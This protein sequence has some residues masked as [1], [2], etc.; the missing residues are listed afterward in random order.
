[1]VVWISHLFP[2]LTIL[3]IP[4]RLCIFAHALCFL[5][6]SLF[7]NKVEIAEF[8]LVGIFGISELCCQVHVGSHG[9]HIVVILQVF[10]GSRIGVEFSSYFFCGTQVEELAVRECWFCD[11]GALSTVVR[12]CVIG[13]STYIAGD[14]V[15]CFCLLFLC[16][17]VWV[18]SAVI[19]TFENRCRIIF[20]V[21]S[22]LSILCRG[23]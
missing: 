22:Q 17:C 23:I 20:R 7:L 12:K 18:V 3:L 2:I 10:V 16:W 9:C 15:D 8:G 6:A 4:F 14:G 5:S 21:A 11:R 19:P 1:M 13:I